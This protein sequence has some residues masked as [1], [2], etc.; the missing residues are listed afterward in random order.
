MVREKRPFPKAAFELG[1]PE[2]LA[3]IDTVWNWG[4]GVMRGE[5]CAADGGDTEF[6]E[7]FLFQSP[8]NVAIDG[9]RRKRI[10][11]FFKPEVSEPTKSL[12]QRSV[13]RPKHRHCRM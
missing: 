2:S 13:P 3:V 9:I 7:V 8:Q 12:T 6:L 5:I 4:N 11:I 1:D 10:S